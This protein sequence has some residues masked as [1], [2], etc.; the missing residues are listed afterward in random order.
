MIYEIWVN[1]KQVGS[2]DDAMR[3]DFLM[4]LGR[5]IACNQEAKICRK[6]FQDGKV[7]PHSCMRYYINI[8]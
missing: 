2:F 1:G 8:D 6:Y 3:E 7:G 5:I 4:M